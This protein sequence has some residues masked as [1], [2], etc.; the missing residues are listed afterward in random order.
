MDRRAGV[1]QSRHRR[2]AKVSD[3]DDFVPSRER[4]VAPT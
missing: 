2:A 1:E 3:F 4:D